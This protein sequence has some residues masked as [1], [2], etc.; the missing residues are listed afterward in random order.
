VG[1]VAEPRVAARPAALAPAGL[2]VAPR[3]VPGLEFLPPAVLRLLP[4]ELVLLAS[5]S[6]SCEGAGTFAGLC[7]RL[8]SRMFGDVDGPFPVVADT[9]HLALELRDRAGSARRAWYRGPLVPF[10]LTRDAGGPYHTADDCRRVSLET[11]ME[12]VTYAAA[13]EV[14]RLLA[15]SDARFAQELMRW[16]RTDCR[17]SVER[18]VVSHLRDRLPG[19]TDRP[20]L[21][22][23]GIAAGIARS[24]AAPSLPRVDPLEL[25]TLGDAAGL[26]AEALAAAWGLTPA[27]AHALLGG[28][29]EALAPAVALVHTPAAGEVSLASVARDAAGLHQ[30]VSTRGTVAAFQA[31]VL[32]GVTRGGPL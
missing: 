12:D 15:A 5:W 6:F 11:G 22:L 14:G 24:F 29:P 30:L 2:L 13:F 16:R 25:A 17:R 26:R 3:A 31:G 9:G 4:V 28:G 32:A 21:L 7:E 18:A 27:A 20:E 1:R 8:D 23:A 19:L 10:P